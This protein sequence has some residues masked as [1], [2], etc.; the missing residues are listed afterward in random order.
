MATSHELDANQRGADASNKIFENPKEG[1]GMTDV[2]PPIVSPQI[3]SDDLYGIK[4]SKKRGRKAREKISQEQIGEP[5]NSIDRVHVDS[6]IPLEVTHEQALDNKHKYSNLG[7]ASRRSKR[8]CFNTSTISTLRTACTVP[9]TLGVLSIGE[10]K[11]VKSSYKQENA[12][13]C[14]QETAIKN[15]MKRSG[16]QSMDQ[17]NE[18]A[19]SASSIFTVQTDN[20]GKAS[21]S[22]QCKSKLSRKSMSCG[23]ELRTTKR[24]KLSSD[25]I[26]KTKNSEEILPNESIHHGLDVMNLNDTSKEKH[27]PLMDET[28]LRKCESHVKKYQCVFCLSSEESEVIL[29]TCLSCHHYNWIRTDS[30]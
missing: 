29:S 25:C 24:S 11:I 19:A 12:K 22:R 14:L 3:S 4:K 26:S 27:C 5:K 15:Q 17:T 28:V 16:K 30:M 8:A 23:K 9:D 10:T 7:K 6:N 13:H 1:N 21:N 18:F 2:L 20:N